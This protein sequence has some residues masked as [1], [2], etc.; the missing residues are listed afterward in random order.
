MISLRTARLSSSGT[1]SYSA[2]LGRQ[3][4]H[5]AKKKNSEAFESYENDSIRRSQQVTQNQ[6]SSEE[7]KEGKLVSEV[8]ASIL[9]P[10]M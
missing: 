5:A 9:R 6:D 10:R 1:S 7:K 8:V 4:E 3:G 2:A